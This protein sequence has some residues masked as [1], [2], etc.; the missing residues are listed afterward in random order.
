MRRKIKIVYPGDREI[1]T[2]VDIKVPEIVTQIS[3]DEEKTLCE[4]Q[5]LV[6]LE[7]V[8][9]QWNG[10]SGQ[11]CPDFTMRRCRSLS[12][13]DFVCL[14]ENNWYECKGCGWEKVTAEYVAERQAKVAHLLDHPELIRGYCIGADQRKANAFGANNQIAWDEKKSL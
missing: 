13:N 5:D 9:A 7:I 2:T 3:P 4:R 10:G 11:E 8:F 12:V 6:A 1:E 14:G